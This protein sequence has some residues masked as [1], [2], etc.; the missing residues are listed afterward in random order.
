MFGLTFSGRTVYRALERDWRMYKLFRFH[1]FG[2][3]SPHSSRGRSHESV[4][5]T[6]WCTRMRMFGVP[7][8][9]CPPGEK[10]SYSTLSAFLGHTPFSDDSKHVEVQAGSETAFHDVLWEVPFILLLAAI[11]FWPEVDVTKPTE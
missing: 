1:E 8:F 4:Q 5:H 3:V 11:A 7:V 9:H 6:K 2:V 10:R